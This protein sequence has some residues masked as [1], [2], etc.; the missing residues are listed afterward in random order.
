M[1]TTLVLFT[2]LIFG[3][4]CG[5]R[6]GS[7]GIRI[8]RKSREQAKCGGKNSTFVVRFVQFLPLQV[9]HVSLQGLQSEL[10]QSSQV[11]CYVDL[12]NA[13]FKQLKAFNEGIEFEV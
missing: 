11:I 12:S 1:Y 10:E 4:L 8:N 2:N 7:N 6:S 5:V 9:V 3:F 13:V